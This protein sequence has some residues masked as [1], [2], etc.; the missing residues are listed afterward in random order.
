MNV[1]EWWQNFAQTSGRSWGTFHA[2]PNYLLEFLDELYLDYEKTKR[3]PNLL[4][5][6]Q[7]IVETKETSRKRLDYYDVIYNRMRTITSVIGTVLNCEFGIPLEKLLDHYVILELSQLRPDEQNWLVE[8][9]LMWIYQYRL[10]QRHRG[11]HLRHVIILDECHR[12]FYTGKDYSETTREMGMPVTDT[13][14]T[15]FRDFGEGLICT[16]NLPSRVSQSLHSNTLTKITGNLGS[17]MDVDTVAEAMGL[18]DDERESIHKLRRAEWIVKLSDYYTEPF[19]ITT[20]DHPVDTNVTDME[21]LERL[22]RLVPLDEKEEKKEFFPNRIQR[23]PKQELIQPDISE[24]AMALLCD[25]AA[26]PIRRLT[27]RY[28]S[29]GLYGRKTSTIKSELINKHLVEEVTLSY[30]PLCDKPV[31]FLSITTKA[32]R[33]LKKLQQPVEFWDEFIG[34]TSLEHRL[35]QLFLTT[36]LKKVGFQVAIEKN[37]GKKRLDLFAVKDNKKCGFEIALNSQINPWNIIK[38]QKHFD[39]LIVICKNRTIAQRTEEIL[40][41]IAYPSILKKI[42][43]CLLKD[44]L[45]ELRGNILP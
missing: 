16:T 31:K 7:L 19:M 28:R 41:N 11:E 24:D 2:G 3:I 45:L 12:W 27:T 5:L 10:V 25:V 40:G 34:K 30:N 43:I 20:S 8:V 9:L 36:Y 1:K 4:D 42:R 33:M 38:T 6:Y 22:H 18:K 35:Y 21:V 26:H 15:Q 14:P 37:L 44:Y 32:I 17:G 29:L 23:K 39:E 13:F